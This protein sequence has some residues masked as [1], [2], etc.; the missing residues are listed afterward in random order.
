LILLPAFVLAA[1]NR[2]MRLLHFD[3]SKRLMTTDFTR[4]TIPLYAILSYT[5]G[6]D[7]FLFEDLMNRTGK[8]KASYE[9]VLFCG[10][11]AACDHI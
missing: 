11:Q 7:E 10:Q 5:W 1:W 2:E 4:K 6:S 8:S 9:K 3:S